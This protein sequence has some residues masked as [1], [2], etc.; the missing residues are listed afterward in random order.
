MSG[1]SGRRAGAR[2]LEF[3]VHEFSG[4]TL[5]PHTAELAGLGRAV[6]I[7]QKVGRRPGKQDTRSQIIRAASAGF[8]EAGYAEASIRG[9]AQRAGV[10]PALVHHY[11]DGKVSLFIEVMG[12]PGGMREVPAEL[13][14]NPASGATI[15]RA[16]LRLWDE[17]ATAAQPSPFLSLVQAVSSSPL[18]AQSVRE[19]IAERIRPPDDGQ[20]LSHEWRV[21]QALIGSQ[22]MGL[23]FQRYILR[24]EPVVTADADQLA[25]W[26]GPAIDR[27]LHEPL[28]ERGSG[29]SDR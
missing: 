14:E 15:V 6:V 20:P 17:H 29:G 3:T 22:L 7:K 25:A 11:F 23:A 2:P 8:A 18:A 21:R 5:G 9:I 12:L 13:R 16:F 27:Y 24:A 28:A 10:D 26:V 4:A 19:F 1:G